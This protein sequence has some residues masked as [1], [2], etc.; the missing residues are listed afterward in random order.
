MQYSNYIKK[1]PPIEQ[2]EVIYSESNSDSDYYSDS[3]SDSD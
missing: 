3:D 2:S 1:L